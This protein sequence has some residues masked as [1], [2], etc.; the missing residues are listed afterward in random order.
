MAISPAGKSLTWNC[1]SNTLYVYDIAQKTTTII[2]AKVAYQTA[3]D[4]IMVSETRIIVSLNGKI[5]NID[6]TVK[7]NPIVNSVQ[8]NAFSSVYATNLIKQ[9]YAVAND[10]STIQL[11]SFTN[12]IIDTI[13][14]NNSIPI[15]SMSFN[16]NGDLY[17][18]NNQGFIVALTETGCPKD[19]QLQNSYCQCKPLFNPRGSGCV[20]PFSYDSKGGNCNC[21][22]G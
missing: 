20:C 5:T 22:D 15:S 2:N 14:I 7:D 16:T 3:S 13:K 4:L 1:D 11:I 9:L 12:Q 21:D 8:P 6:L 19:Q 10:T 18:S 17:I